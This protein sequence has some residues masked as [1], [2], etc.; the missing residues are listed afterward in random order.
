MER[1]LFA[2][3]YDAH[4]TWALV[5]RFM[6][7]GAQEFTLQFLEIAGHEATAAAAAESLLHPFFIGDGTREVVAN[8]PFVRSV[9]LW[10]LSAE[11]LT[12]LRQ[13][14]PAGLFT[15][16]TYQNEGW[17]ENPAFYRRGE[18][19]VGIVSHEGEGICRGSIAEFSEMEQEGLLTRERPSEPWRP[20]NRPSQSA[21]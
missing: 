11:S 16:P 9:P 8:Q 4:S 14:L 1:W 3:D 19:V 17:I 2:E 20:W 13:L 12:V 6:R 18:L 7:V 10:R 21:T 15:A 5:E